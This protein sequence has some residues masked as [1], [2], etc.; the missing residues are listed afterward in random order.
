MYAIQENELSQL[1]DLSSFLD[2]EFNFVNQY[3][4]ILRDVKSDWVDECV[5]C[6]RDD[7][8]H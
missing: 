7:G 2:A 6:Q 1:K 3:A 8:P 4:E 5:F